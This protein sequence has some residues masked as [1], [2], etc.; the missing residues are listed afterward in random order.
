MSIELK[1][2]TNALSTLIEKDPQFQ[3]NLQQCVL[4]NVAKRY[5]K[6]VPETVKNAIETAAKTERDKVASL[7]GSYPTWGSFKLKDNVI[8]MIKTAVDR[9]AK[10]QI[11]DLIRSTI[12][13]A[14]RGLK[15][16]IE[17]AVEESMVHYKNAIIKAEV[18]N[19]VNAALAQ[20]KI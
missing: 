15:E 19:R 14:E 2:D 18:Q 13:E 7:F 16:K 8:D 6:G 20:L 10:S 4:E 11:D 9:E 5:I 1:L 12:A 3:L 17:R